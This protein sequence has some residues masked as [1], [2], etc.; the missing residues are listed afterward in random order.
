MAVL[1]A[2]MIAQIGNLQG[3]AR[4]VNDAGLLRGAT[5]REI[6]LE[7]AGQGNDDLITYLDDILDGLKDN[8]T[9]YNLVRL[10]DKKYLDD[11]E[12]QR[13]FWQQMKEEI[14]QVRQKGYEKT[15]IVDMSEQ[16][17]KLADNTVSAAEEYSEAIADRIRYLEIG[18]AVDSV[19]LIA[20][21]L[22]R[23]NKQLAKKA[24]DILGHSVGDQ[25]IANFARLL[26]NSI[27]E[28]NFVGRYGGDEFLAV[29]YGTTK[30]EVEAILDGLNR[31]ISEF[32]QLNHGNNGFVEI[33]YACGWVL[34]DDM[35]DC[36]FR[37][38]FDKA[39]RNMYE[40]KM[41]SKEHRK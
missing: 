12:V 26:R 34:S 21:M 11:L 36:S 10:E 16:Y 19:L 40:N 23:R 1:I 29:I 2:C 41:R 24:N 9:K 18:T 15:N 20:I 31:N 38:L 32:N 5:Q 25:L 30:P 28:K 14:S 17:F 35:P 27:P 8:S 4:V 39:D 3:T 13:E 6:K 7:I 37:V 22:R 33:S